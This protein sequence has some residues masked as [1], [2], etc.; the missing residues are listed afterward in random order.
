VK[1]EVK[2]QN[3]EVLD[4]L[5]SRL[6]AHGLKGRA[7][8]SVHVEE[9]YE[10]I[11]QRYRDGEIT[12]E[13]YCEYLTGFDSAVPGDLPGGC[14]VIIVASPQPQFQVGFT[15]Q[16]KVNRFIIPPTYLHHTDDEAEEIL[17][18]VLEPAGYRVSEARLPEKLLAVRSGLARYGRNNIAYIDGMGSFHRIRAYYTDL[19]CGKYEWG[20]VQMMERCR[21]CKACIKSCPS[22]AISGKR[23]VVHAEK[24]ITFHNE[25]PFTWPEWVKS[26]WDMDSKCVVGCM[27]CQSNCPLN[28]PWW[29]CVELTD[30]FSEQETQDLMAGKNEEELPAATVEKLRRLYL[31]EYLYNLPRNLDVLFQLPYSSTS[32]LSSGSGAD[33]VNCLKKSMPSW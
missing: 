18:Q 27:K 12:S 23:F 33:D 9:L 3:K 2:V 15:R 4:V 21:D 14:S 7:V 16:G 30:I 22:G 11:Q 6:E 5:F 20:P 25:M 24:C 29:N 19:P 17:K 32:S 31:L 28:K 1:K 26:A 8:S 13:V 10:E